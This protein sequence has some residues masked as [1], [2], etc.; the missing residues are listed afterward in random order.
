LPGRED[1]FVDEV[2]TSVDVVAD[3]IVRAMKPVLDVPF[4]FFGHSMGALIAFAVTQ[5]LA[6]AGEP[7]PQRV[8]VSAHRAPDL[9]DPQP[10]L[11]KLAEPQFVERLRSFGGTPELVFADPELTELYLPVLRADFTMCETYEF[12]PGRLLPCPISVFGGQD[13][14]T[15]SSVELDGWRNHTSAEFDMRLFPG[16]HFYLQGIEPHLA[17]HMRR[18][19]MW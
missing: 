3:A 19:L 1:R 15:V 12:R 2:I 6:E 10:Q 9:P 7:L 13:D 11:H 4:A 14:A 17:G 18:V 5:R 16:G 8:F